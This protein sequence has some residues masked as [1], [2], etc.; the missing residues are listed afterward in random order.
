MKMV[1]PVALEMQRRSW[2]TSLLAL[3]S[4][5]P[6]LRERGVPHYTFCDFIDLAD[7]EALAQGERLADIMH[8]PESGMT[9]RESVVY[10]GLSY[11]DLERRLG[12]AKAK[13]LFAT[14]GRHAFL[15]VSVLEEII[16]S[17]D[18]DVIVTTNSP[19]SERAAQ[20]AGRKLGR[21]TALISDLFG[22]REMYQYDSDLVCVLSDITKHNLVAMGVESN[23]IRITGNPATDTLAL[24][25]ES[26]NWRSSVLGIGADEPVVLWAD[27]TAYWRN[28]MTELHSRTTDEISRDLSLLW[29]ACK[30]SNAH[31]LVRPHPS[32]PRSQFDGWI[33]AQGN[34]R[35][36]LAD[37]YDLYSLI[38]S[39]DV[40]AT[41]TSTVGVEAVM[42]GRP[43]L[44]VNSG[45]ESSDVPLA[46]YGFALS[47][48]DLCD[49]GPTLSTLLFDTKQRD[50]LQ[51]AQAQLRPDGQ[52]AKRVVD[53]VEQLVDG[54]DQ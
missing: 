50:K 45:G 39:V 36:R 3:T 35:V 42:L 48:P 18:P 28:N 20:I 13:D 37:H 40:V 32:Q 26:S 21:A 54:W 22:V 5:A 43:V 1:L 9:R 31:L 2:R 27:Q 29:R 51:R 14:Q 23:T 44:T 7:R 16:R 52:A 47:V 11:R 4:A 41:I 25:R 46:D 53:A 15:P 6:F 10:L 17:L 34:D 30:S 24:H 49:V 19:K 33:A 8:S 12:Q 38:R